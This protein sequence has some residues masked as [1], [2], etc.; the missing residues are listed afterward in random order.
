M[1]ELQVINNSKTLD[2]REVAEM[3]GKEHSYVLEMIQGRKGKQGEDIAPSPDVFPVSSLFPDFRDAGTQKKAP[4]EEI[5][6]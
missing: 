6:I 2:S 1:Q 5:S 3:L 4:E